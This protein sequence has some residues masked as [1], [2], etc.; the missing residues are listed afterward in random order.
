MSPIRR[1]FHFLFGW[2]GALLPTVTPTGSDLTTLSEL[3]KQVYDPVIAD[4]TNTEPFTWNLF[5]DGTDKLGGQGWFFE[6]KMGGNQ[7]GIG[8]RPEKGA[9]PSAGRQRWKQGLISW[10][11]LY[12]AFELTGQVIEAAKQNVESFANARTEEIEGLTR[13][14]IKDMNRQVFGNG[15]GVLANVVNTAFSPANTFFVT[16][17]TNLRLNMLFDVWLTTA[18]AS[19]QIPV[20]NGVG[21]QILG[22]AYNATTGYTAVTIDTAGDW[23]PAANQVLI[24]AGAGAMVASTATFYKYEM[25]GLAA[26]VDDGVLVDTY[27]GI[28][29]VAA[30]AWPLWKANVLK[31]AAV[32]RNLTTDLLQQGED[33]VWKYTNKRP[34]FIRMNTGQRRKFFDLVAPD[35][36][37]M[38]NRIDAGWETL[39]YNGLELTVDPDCPPGKIYMCSKDTIKKYYLRRFGLMDFDGLT[40]R[41]K[42]GYDIYVGYVG[43]YGNLGCKHPNANVRIDD[44]QEPTAT[45]YIA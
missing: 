26:I 24:R 5:G 39:E 31:N 36:R 23:T 43:C 27:L 7:E 16:D 41:Q 37:Y 14:V 42:A 10:K 44:L 34:D 19:P 2:L 4:Q 15:T 22:L 21:H 12:G 45:P 18:T 32:A 38:T 9:L 6:T 13:D 3:L 30:T 40:I 25:E 29:R 33:F 28:N 11:N 17:G 35:K 8:A 1:L 20:T